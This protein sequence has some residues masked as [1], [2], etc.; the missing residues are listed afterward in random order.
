M[1]GLLVFGAIQSFLLEY[2]P[3]TSTK[4]RNII[5][6][7]SNSENG[8]WIKMDIISTFFGS[9]RQTKQE[10]GRTLPLSYSVSRNKL[11]FFL[12]LLLSGDLELNPGPKD[13]CGTC[14]KGVRKNQHGLACD[15]C[16]LWYHRK[17]L[18][19]DIPSYQKFHDDESLE[20]LCPTCRRPDTPN[21]ETATDPNL[22]LALV[23]VPQDDPGT[24]TWK[25]VSGLKT[26][27]I[28]SGEGGLMCHLDEIH[29]LLV[30]FQPDVLACCETWLLPGY[31]KGPI[32]TDVYAFYSREKPAEWVGAQGVG[33]FIKRTLEFTERQDLDHKYLMNTT[34]E[35]KKNS[36]SKPIIVSCIYR[37]HS[38]R[39]DWYTHLEELAQQ[40][41]G[42]TSKAILTGDFN[43]DVLKPD[44]SN[45]LINLMEDYGFT[46]TIQAPTRITPTSRTCIDLTFTNL[47][48]HTSGVACIAVADHLMNFII[49]GERAH[50]ATHRIITT[51]SIKGL[52]KE[53]LLS[54]LQLVPWQ[55][56]ETFEDIDDCYHTWST[57]FNEIL[58]LHCPVKK[59]R[60][61]A[62]NKRQSWYNDEVDASRTARD[63]AHLTAIKTN[64]ESDWQRYKQLK[65]KTNYLTRT[66]KR[67]YYHVN[68][69]HAKGDSKQMWTV[70]KELLPRPRDSGITKLDV[71]GTTVTDPDAIANV[72]NSFFTNV[73][74]KLAEKIPESEHP[75]LYYLKKNMPEIACTFQF[76]EVTAEDVEKL[77][78]DLPSNKATGVDNV[79]ATLLKMSAPVISSSL[80]HVLNKS[81]RTGRVPKD[82]KSARI[83]AIFK[84]GNRTDTGNYRPI[85][86]L[87]VISKLLEKLVHRQLYSYCTVNNLISE[88]QSGFRKGHST[89]TSLHRMTEQLFEGLNS[90]HCVGM[91]ALDLKKAFD[92]VDHSIVVN[93]LEYYGVR[94]VANEWFRSYL[95]NRTQFAQINGHLSDPENIETGVPQGSILGP[96]LFIIYVNDLSACLQHST[97]NMYAD[98]TAF[99][100]G[101]KD[102][103]IVR[104]CLQEDT[105]Y[106]HDWLNS[107][108][109]SLNVSKTTSMIICNDQKRRTLDS[110]NLDIT[111]RDETIEHSKCTPYLG[112]EL[113]DRILFD[114]QLQ[115]QIGKIN[116]SIGAL[117][118]VSKYIPIE[119]RKTLFNTIVL[120]HY[121]YC[122][123]VWGSYCDSKLIRLQR[124]QNRAMRIILN[125][126]PRCH[127]PPLLARTNF[128]SVNQRFYVNMCVT[129]WKVVH[130]HAPDHLVGMF[131]LQ[132][133]QPRNMVTRSMAKLDVNVGPSHPRSFR[134][135][136]SKAWNDLP[137]DLQT[138]STLS[139]F[140]YEIK[141][142]TRSKIAPIL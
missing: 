11:Y 52:N 2:E 77:L 88:A 78:N 132:S 108:K 33:F 22:S 64:K 39:A 17:C 29:G 120:P 100:I 139:S 106:V 87:P 141:K 55:V 104:E 107:N 19:M 10:T 86:I 21:D 63:E 124:T 5:V 59:T 133:T 42:S 126:E 3:S 37:H 128:L 111:V 110:D 76:T 58:D 14:G 27:H 138:I 82:M 38:N 54:D 93:K 60:V 67:D 121:D 136:G 57:L 46:Q 53:D 75:P 31:D 28:N 123:T 32:E 85:S 41:D 98:D 84:K 23:P 81:L 50:G 24:E 135:R 142:H 9:L 101:N 25:A 94:G 91:V 96:L 80:A 119:T 69:E 89:E 62:R 12:V 20:Y 140:K 109:L 118:R 70:L 79:S 105:E 40:L 90:G 103:N 48:R 47:Q 45:T 65:N 97:A 18:Q 83:T 36:K 95:S 30:D 122:S 114:K 127:V 16:D 102:I 13:P 49:L 130:G 44:Q 129:M 68:I 112:I 137:L 117:K 74:A 92:T 56:I 4:G 1:I 113:D 73:G 43:I 72:F 26:A 116:R 134:C 34:I 8:I 61:S 99:Y 6:N 35:V 125:E 131:P 115:R 15:Q 71:D 7:N 51:R 66:T